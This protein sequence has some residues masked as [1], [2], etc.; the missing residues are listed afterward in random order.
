MKSS[1]PELLEVHGKTTNSVGVHA[2]DII[3][4][5]ES[6][7]IRETGRAYSPHLATDSDVLSGKHCG[8]WGRFIAVRLYL[9]SAYLETQKSQIRVVSLGYC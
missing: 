2:F 3:A 6:C 9:H 5:G 8:I 4:T 7:H 1:K